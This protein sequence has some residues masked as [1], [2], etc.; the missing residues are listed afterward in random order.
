V[1]ANIGTAEVVLML[2][3]SLVVLAGFVAL[4]ALGVRLGTRGRRV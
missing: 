4:V 1:I 3:V 2:V